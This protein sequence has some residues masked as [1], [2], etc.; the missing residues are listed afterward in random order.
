MDH[1]LINFGPFREFLPSYFKNDFL[2]QKGLSWLMG[3]SQTWVIRK[4]EK[5]I[6]MYIIKDFDRFSKVNLLKFNFHW[7][8]CCLTHLGDYFVKIV[9]V[10]VF[11]WW[12]VV[13]LILQRGF[14]HEFNHEVEFLFCLKV[15]KRVGGVTKESEL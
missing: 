7:C 10:L 8:G 4:Y 1:L 2:V 15:V 9:K 14:L 11:D 3:N 6:I 12:Q 13:R 5:K